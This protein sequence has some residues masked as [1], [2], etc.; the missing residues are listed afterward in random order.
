VKD[1][2][3]SV[4][5]VAMIA[6]GLKVRQKLQGPTLLFLGARVGALFH[7]QTLYEELR[8]FSQHSFAPF[9][10]IENFQACVRLLTQDRFSDAEIHSILLRSL[11]DAFVQHIDQYVASLVKL[12]FFQLI[13]T[14]NIDA[15]LEAAL[16][17]IGLRMENDFNVFIPGTHSSSSIPTLSKKH[18]INKPP[19]LV[20][21]YGE[22]AIGNYSLKHRDK[23]FAGNTQLSQQLRSMRDWNILM[24]GFDPVWDAATVSILFPC[25][26]TLWYVNEETPSHDSEIFKYLQSR[27]TQCLLGVKGSSEKFFQSLYQQIVGSTPLPSLAPPEEPPPARLRQSASPL[28]MG[29]V[30]QSLT[31]SLTTQ[32]KTDVL[33]LAT[34]K[35]EL[36][37][38]L[39]R[40]DG[41][42]TRRTIQGRTYYDLGKVG[43]AGVSLVQADEMGNALD[44]LG[45]QI[46]ELAPACII[47]LG[48]AWG[49]NYKG[50]SIGN[51]LVSDRILIYDVEQESNTYKRNANSGIFTYSTQAQQ[52]IPRRL[53]NLF[54]NGSIILNKK[55]RRLVPVTFGPIFSSTE[56]T[57]Q[58]TAFRYV[59]RTA[60]NAIG[61]ETRD[62]ALVSLAQSYQENCLLV[63][64]VS[65]LVDVSEVADQ[66]APDPESI[67]ESAA[68]FILDVIALGGFHDPKDNFPPK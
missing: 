29:N 11:Q 7:S 64:A 14:T 62:S 38:T 15:G 53:L 47:I 21:L 22:L 12:N 52:L 32:Y 51:I 37:A 67:L 34:T 66:D 16:S 20:K 31:S 2:S 19:T 5:D 13:V 26:R 24:V 56:A 25:A 36:T 27:K 39:K 35:R 48:T 46:Q 57:D 8:P 6:Q 65:D 1:M 30:E 3:I 18:S 41:E 59:S 23:L 28:S 40:H 4:I 61:I 17:S 33:L 42:L 55:T 58:K 63:K 50:Q 9:E 44:A 54:K 60:L 43:A 10:Q 45:G 49:F 68:Q